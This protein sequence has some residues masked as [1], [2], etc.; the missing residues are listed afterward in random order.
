VNGS[1]DPRSCALMAQATARNCCKYH[2]IGLKPKAGNE[3]FHALKELA[4]AV[5]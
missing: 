1:V 5:Q 3:S 2:E 4:A